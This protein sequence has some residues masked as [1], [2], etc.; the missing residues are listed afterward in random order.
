MAKFHQKKNW[1]DVWIDPA[2][3]DVLLSAAAGSHKGRLHMEKS[4]SG[5][6][7]RGLGFTSQLPLNRY[8][9]LLSSS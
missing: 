5:T 7:M 2:A 9:L 1:E 6:L 3:E 4:L 8:S